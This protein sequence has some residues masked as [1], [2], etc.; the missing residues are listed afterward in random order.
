MQI[1]TLILPRNYRPTQPVCNIFAFPFVFFSSNSAGLV[2]GGPISFCICSYGSS[3]LIICCIEASNSALR[4]KAFYTCC[5]L[6]ICL[7]LAASCIV[8]LSH[9]KDGLH[10]S[11]LPL[12]IACSLSFP[13]FS[14]PRARQ[15]L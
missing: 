10:S 14:P 5:S 15:C 2:G 13:Y 7:L 9:H 3:C 11:T 8:L 1:E 12:A 6:V 4:C